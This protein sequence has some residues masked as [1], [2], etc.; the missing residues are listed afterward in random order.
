MR[1]PVGAYY[2]VVLS[3]RLFFCPVLSVSSEQARRSFWFRWN[4]LSRACD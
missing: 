4:I 2:A 1:P 3:L